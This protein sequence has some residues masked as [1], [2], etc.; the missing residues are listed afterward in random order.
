M[1]SQHTIKGN[2]FPT[3]ATVRVKTF[4]Y[5][6]TFKDENGKTIG[7]MTAD[8]GEAVPTPDNSHTWVCDEYAD[9]RNTKDGPQERVVYATELLTGKG[10]KEDPYLIKTADYWNK[11]RTRTNHDTTKNEYYRLENDIT[12][13]STVGT[14]EKPFEGVFDGN[15]K[16]LTVNYSN[17]DDEHT[18]PFAYAKD[19]TIINLT[20]AGEIQGTGA[21]ASGILGENEGS[22]LIDHCNVMATIE[23]H[24]YVGGISV[25]A[26][27]NL[28]IS[29]TTFT[30]KINGRKDCGGFVALGTNTLVLKNCVFNPMSGSSIRSGATFANK[31][32]ATLENCKYYSALGTPQG[33]FVSTIAKGSGT[34]A[35]PYIIASSG[36]WDKLQYMTSVSD[37]FGIYFK[38]NNDLT[39]N[40]VIGSEQ[41]A[42]EGIFDGAGT[43]SHWIIQLIILRDQLLP[44][45]IRVMLQL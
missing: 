4:D 18:A 3:S 5:N 21:K 43:H 13:T 33:E 8:Y 1:I 9:W 12:V 15:G 42:F 32:Y 2:D 6:Y 23:G 10:S 27:G 16:T 31:A 26:E 44:L 39:V 7:I 22:T 14:A 11:F 28:E 25:G 29:N 19:A 40:S 45:L 38:M 41:N 20:V 17:N 34:K 35:D 30:G 36:D 37:T 24:D